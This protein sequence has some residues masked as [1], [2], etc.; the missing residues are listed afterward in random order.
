MVWRP[1]V[2]RLRAWCR[3]GLRHGLA[4]V[5]MRGKSRR[6]RDKQGRR[7]AK[8]ALV[9][10]AAESGVYGF[11]EA[12]GLKVIFN[13][14]GDDISVERFDDIVDGAEFQG[15]SLEGTV[16]LR[17]NENDGNMPGRGVLFQRLADLIAVGSR[18][19][20]VEQNQ[21]GHARLRDGDAF[22]TRGGFGGIR[23]VL[24]HGG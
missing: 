21:I 2:R 20:Q 8:V 19:H 13:F 23:V 7:D 5:N 4:Q 9:S 17:G 18:H 12:N 22:I 6:R 16:G 11:T 24:D 14:G 15:C 3:H 1:Y 10:P